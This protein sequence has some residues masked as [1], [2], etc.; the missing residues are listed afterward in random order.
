MVFKVK[1]LQHVLQILDPETYVSADLPKSVRGRM[2]MICAILNDSSYF[3]FEEVEINEREE[4]CIR[5]TADG[6]DDDRYVI[7]HGQDGKERLKKNAPQLYEQIFE[8][9]KNHIE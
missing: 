4:F 1:D 3:V 2:A 9:L 7:R 8:Y 6:Y 5:L